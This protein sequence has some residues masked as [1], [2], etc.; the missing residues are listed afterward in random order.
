MMQII[1]T[2]ELNQ[3]PKV[4]SYIHQS[5]SKKSVFVKTDEGYGLV[6]FDNFQE[7]E[8][9]TIVPEDNEMKQFKNIG[10]FSYL[11]KEDA[12]DH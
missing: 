7:Q 9:I 10:K 11:C 12:I 8:F 6:R 2:N 4:D 5:H 1:T 3:Y